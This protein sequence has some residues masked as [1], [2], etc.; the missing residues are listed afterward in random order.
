MRATGAG[1]RTVLRMGD[2]DT[3]KALSPR[4]FDPT[5]FYLGQ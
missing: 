4:Q 2:L 3:G 5:V 1:T